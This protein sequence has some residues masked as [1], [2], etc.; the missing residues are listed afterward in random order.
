[1]LQIG[2][3]DAF[4]VVFGGKFDVGICEGKVR[5]LKSF[6]FLLGFVDFTAE[7]VAFS[8]QF[9]SFLGSFDDIVG[10][11][12]FCLPV[13][14]AICITTILRAFYTSDSYL[15]LRFLTLFFLSASSMA[16]L[17]LSSSI[18][19]CSASRTSL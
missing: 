19:F 6:E 14:R 18:A 17:C 2:L 13:S 8:L 3:C 4:I 10:L 9:F 11:R 5:I 7:L 12:V 15:A 1:L 16:I